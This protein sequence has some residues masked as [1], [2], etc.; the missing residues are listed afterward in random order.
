MKKVLKNGSCKCWLVEDLVSQYGNHWRWKGRKSTLWT[1][2]KITVQ[3][4]YWFYC[5]TLGTSHNLSVLWFWQLSI[6]QGRGHLTRLL[7]EQM[8]THIISVNSNTL[9]SSSAV[10]SPVCGWHFS[11]GGC[12]SKSLWSMKRWERLVLTGS[13]V[14]WMILDNSGRIFLCPG[15]KL[16]ELPFL[17]QSLLLTLH[18]NTWGSY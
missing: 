2:F 11:L 13:H 7:C 1:R 14:Q 18:T 6:H 3:I 5:M 15:S 16:T 17:P 10:T 8:R 12:F 9:L 4:C